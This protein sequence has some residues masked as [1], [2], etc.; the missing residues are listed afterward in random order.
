MSAFSVPNAL[1]AVRRS[2][3]PARIGVALLLALGGCSTVSSWFQP[4]PAP[5][6]VSTQP[7][8]G[9]KPYPNL[10][11]VPNQ[12]PPVS[13]P[14][15]RKALVEGLNADRANAQYSDQALTDQPTGA[16]PGQQSHGGSPAGRGAAAPDRGCRAIRSI[17]GQC[18]DR[19]RLGRPRTGPAA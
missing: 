5:A 7:V 19:D 14:D 1:A 4:A 3:S 8:A 10:A 15:Q 16:A 2:L 13:S 11:T 17:G 12:A 6:R 18:G 9:D